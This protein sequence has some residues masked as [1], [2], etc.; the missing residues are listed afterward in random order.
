MQQ[1][2]GAEAPLFARPQLRLDPRPAGGWILR[3]LT[4]LPDHPA[5]I[6]DHLFAWAARAPDRPFLREREGGDGPWHG[7]TYAEAAEAVR[8]IGRGLL[9]RGLGRQRGVAV[10]SGNSI[11]HALL[12][13]AAQAV[14]VPYAPVS[15]PYS[16]MS[17]DLGKLRHVLRLVKPGLIYA[18]SAARFARALS[19]EEADGAAILCAD[20]AGMPRA[21]PFDALLGYPADAAIDRA[22]AAVDPDAP[23]KLLFTSGSTGMPKGVVT[24]HRMMT[25]NQEQVTAGWPF[26]RQHPPVLLDWLPWNHV[27]GSSHNLNLVLRHGGTLWIDDGR[28]LPGQIERTLRNLR[29]VA[30]TLSFNVPKGYELLVPRL[31]ADDALARAF[32][33][34]MQVM[35]YAAA[36]LA[37]PLWRRLEDLARAHAPGRTIPMVSSWGLTETA[38]VIT[39]THIEDAPSG[40]IGTPVPGVELKLLPVE[41]KLEARVRGA[42]VTRGYWEDPAATAAAFDEEGFFITGDALAWIDPADPARGFRFDGRLTEDFKLAS[43]TRV[44]AGAMRLRILAALHDAARDVLV[45][46][47]GSDE[48]GLL[49]IPHDHHRGSLGDPALAA[50]VA[51]GLRR[52]NAAGGGASSLTITRA[53]FLAE[54]LSLDAGEVT[55]KGSLN[56]RAILAR[57]AG[58]LGRLYDDGAPE[59]IR[60]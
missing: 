18:E 55:D 22:I 45:V 9:E 21:E 44:H 37:A 20:P 32:F 12:A 1:S 56:G 25:T 7:V 57:R 34:E 24:S 59:V 19:T 50:S 8:R 16:L 58:V 54:P 30:P 40:C 60:P 51:E 4:S 43:G 47:E 13:L 15:T 38:P 2:V 3:S 46:G 41:G 48:I 11:Q 52:V 10:L 31:E 42:N 28:P 26:L 14:G 17:E 35:L 27:F 36:A 49:L 33:A 6:T 5:R 23:V 39:A 53:M 29:E